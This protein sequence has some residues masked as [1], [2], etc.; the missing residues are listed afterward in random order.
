MYFTIEELRKEYIAGTVTVPEYL[1]SLR[2]KCSASDKEI[3]IHLLTE[4]E[5][6]PYLLQL[7][8]YTPDELPLYGIPF[9]IKDN[10]DLA[11]IPTTAG[12]PEFSYTPERSAFVVEQLVKAG[13]IPI[14]KT[15]MDQFATGLVGTRSPYGA[16]KNSFDPSYISGGSS[17]GSAVAVAKGLCSFSLGTDTAGSGRVPAAFNNLLGVK[18]TRGLLSIQG[19]VLACRSLDCVS[20]FALCAADAAEIMNI[21]TVFNA[22]DPYSRK[23]VN[24]KKGA[25]PPSFNYGVPEEEQLQFFGN[26]EYQASFQRAVQLLDD[27]GGKRVDIDFTPFLSAARLLYEGPWVAERT[28]AVGGFLESRPEAGDA[29]VRSIICSSERQTD[30]EVFQ[31]MY[32]LQG[33]KHQADMIMEDVDLLVTPT[34]GTCYTIEEVAAD[35][36]G[37]NTTLGYY[38]NFMNLLDY[39]CVAV[40]GGMTATVPFGLS[41]VGKAFDDDLL[42]NLGGLLHKRSGFPMGGGSKMPPSPPEMDRS[43]MIFLA[44]CGAHL[45]G[46]PLHHQLVERDACLVQKT[47][48]S[49]SYQMFALTGTPAKPG[50]IRNEQAGAAIDV[51]VYGLSPQSFATFVAQIPHP[52]GIGKVELAD[53]SWVPGFI[54][55]SEVMQSGEDITHFGGWRAYR[56]SLV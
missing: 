10:I 46:L 45:Q 56:K 6:E 7:A 21:V 5:L 54:A 42:L 43:D 29:T 1:A 47:T 12:C 20:V 26:K 11:N 44:V 14:G 38:T 3:W 51:E 31:A 25:V 35:P 34:A 41:L 16:C 2:E 33:Y 50:L 28:L 48:T 8:Q 37:L 49:S 18:P 53:G 40:P 55:E 24:R 13:A 39:C 22:A 17:S 19:V 30:I 23:Q 15:N 32:T 4:N 36:I 9:A 52:L 27:L